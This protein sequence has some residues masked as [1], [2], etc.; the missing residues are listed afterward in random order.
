MTPR[1]TPTLITSLFLA[2]VL[3]AGPALAQD[4]ADGVAMDAE[5]ESAADESAADEE[6]DARVVEETA[7]SVVE[8]VEVVSTRQEPGVTYLFV[9][10]RYRSLV[11]PKFMINLFADGGRSVLVHSAGPELGIRKDGFETIVTAS[12][13][14]YR[15]K[16]TPFKAKSD[17]PD[18]WEIAESKA[19]M[20]YLMADFLW[21]Q[22]LSATVAINFGLGAG[23][24]IVFGEINHD[25]AYPAGGDA[26][27]QDSFERCPRIGA[28]PW[29][30]SDHS[31]RYDYY[32]EPSW[33][34]GG[35]KPNLF[36]WLALP[37]FGVRVQPDPKVVMRFDTGFSTSG[38]FFGIAADY[39]L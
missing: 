13:A 22:D 19:K 30:G 31:E 18:A 20:L 7:P 9:G 1:P 4:E 23:F 29:C 34:N 17:P 27:D 15:M 28:H 33:A 21:S 14:S 38:F 6:S 25:Q 24:G 10:A 37:Q 3:G 2:A 8:P 26:S 32:V 5:D 36:P 16:D 11:V 35:S 39:G 12:Y